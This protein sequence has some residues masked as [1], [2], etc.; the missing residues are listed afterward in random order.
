MCIYV[1]DKV[2]IAA[3]TPVNANKGYQSEENRQYLQKRKLKCLIQHKA[4]PKNN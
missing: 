2:E 1:L 4:T 3:Q